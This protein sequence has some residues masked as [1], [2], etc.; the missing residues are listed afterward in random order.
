VPHATSF[1]D[2]RAAIAS[3]FAASR[4]SL[5]APTLLRCFDRQSPDAAASTCRACSHNNAAR[6]LAHWAFLQR[7]LK[8]VQS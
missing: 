4:R 6:F 5:S 1:G 3:N 2:Q 8:A 7:R